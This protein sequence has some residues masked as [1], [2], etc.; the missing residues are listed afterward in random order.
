MSKV[1]QRDPDGW[2]WNLTGKHTVAI[3]RHPGPLKV[4]LREKDRV[5]GAPEE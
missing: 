5:D 4:D 3:S 1:L 2:C